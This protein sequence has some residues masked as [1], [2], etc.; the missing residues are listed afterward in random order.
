MYRLVP[1]LHVAGVNPTI[2]MGQVLGFMRCE[3]RSLSFSLSLSLSLTA[4]ARHTRSLCV[5]ACDSASMRAHTFLRVCLC[6]CVH[7]FVWCCMLCLSCFSAAA[8]SVWLKPPAL[9]SSPQFSISVVLHFGSAKTGNRKV[10]RF[11]FQNTI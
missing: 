4:T 7:L 1:D 9:S 5:R 10:S 2:R 11:A 3:F 6:A 8:A